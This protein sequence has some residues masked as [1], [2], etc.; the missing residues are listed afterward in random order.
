MSIVSIDQQVQ[1]P[2]Y[3]VI[4][5]QQDPETVITTRLIISDTRVNRVNLITIEKGPQG[6]T[7]PQGL[8]G[9]PGKDG[10]TFDILS[11]ASGGTNN[12]SFQSGYI[13]YYDGNKIASS[14]V[15]INNIGGSQSSNI[16]GVVASS[17]LQG[18]YSNNN[19]VVDLSLSLG[20]G[21][22]FNESNAVA[23]DNTIARVSQLQLGNLEGILPISKGGTN[24]TFFSQNRLVYFDGSKIRSLPIE[25]GRFL[26]S[27]NT[28]VQ[29]IAGSGL[30]GGGT[31]N[32]P[33]GSIVLNISESSDIIIE[34]NL[35]RLSNTGVAGNY[36]KVWTDDK[37]RVVSGSALTNAD[38]I[39]ILGYTPYH[40]GNDGAGSNLDADL[41]DGQQGAFY[42][43]ASN[44]TGVLST[45]RLPDAPVSPGLYTKVAINT[46]G[47]VEGVYYADQ[48]DII[49]SLGYIPLSTSGGSILGSLDV[50]Q[51]LNVDGSLSVGDNLP[52]LALNNTN[53]LPSAPRGFT[54]RYGGLYNNKTGI[55]AYYP[56]DNELKLVTNIFASGTD[57]SGGDANTEQD[58]I[59]G[60][61]ANSIFIVDNLEGSQATVLL[62]HIADTLYVDTGTDQFVNGLKTFLNGIAVDEQIIILDKSVSTKPPLDVKSNNLLVTNLN[63]DLLDGQHGTFYRNASNVTGSFDY[64][65]VKFDHI[66]GTNN[67]VP[68]FSDTQNP[69]AGRITNSNL[70]QDTSGNMRVE[71]NYNLVVGG[72]NNSLVDAS[73]SLI[74]GVNNS[75]KSENSTA[76]GYGNI[77]SGDNSLAVNYRSQTSADAS[78]SIAA[79]S[80]GHAWLPNQFAL[81]AFRVFENNVSIQH[82]QQSTATMHLV[83]TEAH[84]SWKTLQPIVPIP[85]NKSIGY[86]VELLISKAFDTGVAHFR[87]ESGIVKNASFRDTNNPINVINITSHPQQA[88]KI[89]G[90][91]NSQIKTHA[92][93]YEFGGL[94]RQQQNISVT[95]IPLRLQAVSTQNLD[96]YY[97]YRPEDVSK[98]GT[99]HRLND[100]NLILDI[101]K[102]LF[103]GVFEQNASTPGIR[104]QSKNHQMMPGAKAQIV[105]TPDPVS[106]IPLANGAHT[107]VG[108]SS[109]DIFYTRSTV[110]LSGYLSYRAHNTQNDIA[111]L[112]IDQPSLFNIDNRFYLM[113]SGNLTGSVVYNTTNADILSFLRPGMNIKVVTS[114]SQI[115]DRIVNAVNVTA[116]SVI[117]NDPIV[118]GISST[119][120]GPVSLYNVE[121]TY[122]LLKQSNRF[123][124]DNYTGEVGQFFANPLV[125]TSGV[126]FQSFYFNQIPGSA[127]APTGY[128]LPF[129]QNSGIYERLDLAHRPSIAI[130]MLVSKQSVYRSGLL[131]TITPLI[132]NTGSVTLYH[133]LDYS[134]SY[135]F[136]PT[137]FRQYQGVYQRFNNGTNSR[138]AIFNQQLQP[139]SI[140]FAPV[141]Y[142]LV[143]GYG[144]NDNDKFYISGVFDQYRLYSKQSLDYE[145][146][147]TYSIRIKA[148]DNSQTHTLEQQK[149]IYLNNKTNPYLNIYDL[150][151]QS[152]VILEP[153]SY[154]LPTNL[155]GFEADGGPVTL[156]AK[157]KNWNS[158]PDWLTFNT[159]TSTFSGI[160]SGCD[161]GSQTIRVSATNASGQT[162]HIDLRLVITDPSVS[163]LSYFNNTLLQSN[164]PQIRNINLSSTFFNENSPPSSV[165]ASLSCDGSYYPFVSFETAY[166]NFSGL[167]YNNSHLIEVTPVLN[168]GYPTVT[169]TG[170]PAL[171]ATGSIIS[172]YFSSPSHIGSLAPNTKV[173][174]VYKPFSWSGTPLLN[175]AKS[176][177]TVFDNNYD[178][179][180]Y[181]GA[182]ILADT[183]YFFPRTTLKSWNDYSFD[184]NTAVLQ[185]NDYILW[186]ENEE[187]IL[188]QQ[189][190]S[191]D[192]SLTVNTIWASGYSECP[193]G[194]LIKGKLF[195]YN[196]HQYPPVR[197]T[198]NPIFSGFQFKSVN[199][200]A[201]ETL[202]ISS[203]SSGT[204]NIIFP[205]PINNAV[206]A[207]YNLGLNSWGE[208]LDENNDKLITDSSE[209]LISDSFFDHG[210]RIEISNN[211]ELLESNNVF[212]HN[213]RLELQNNWDYLLTEDNKSLV[214]DYAIIAKSGD[215]VL[216]YPGD[217]NRNINLYYPD[218]SPV[219]SVIDYSK[220]IYYTLGSLIDFSFA[221][222]KYVLRTNIP[223][224]GQ[225]AA[226]M[227]VYSGGLP[228]TSNYQ[229]SGLQNYSY[230]VTDEC[231]QSSL[232]QGIKGFS[233][234]ETGYPSNIQYSTGIVNFYTEPGTGIINLFFDQQH[235]LDTRD[236]N[237]VYLHNFIKTSSA[238]GSTPKVG[239]YSNND[240]SN[241]GPSS[242]RVYNKLL[243]PNSGI[244]TNGT[245]LAN[246]DRNHGYQTKSP[247]FINHVP[248]RFDS[249]S[250]SLN[251]QTAYN[252]GLQ[253]KNSLFDILNIVGNK[254]IV[255]DS[256]NYL[257]KEAGRPDHFGHAIESD[258][259]T[260]GLPFIGSAFNNH[261]NFYDLRYDLQTLERILKACSFEYDYNGSSS[262]LTI[263]VPSG[264]VRPFDDL[265][266]RFATGVGYDTNDVYKLV[267]TQTIRPR[268]ELY[269][270]LEPLKDEL[271]LESSRSYAQTN[272]TQKLV[273]N[274]IPL[275]NISKSVN[276]ACDLDLKLEHR[277]QPGYKINYNNST[278]DSYTILSIVSGFSFSGFIPRYNNVISTNIDS[279]IL[280]EHIEHASIFHSG[281]TSL[282][283]GGRLLRQATSSDIGYT[284]YYF[285]GSSGINPVKTS[286]SG[287][288]SSSFP[289]TEIINS[290][291]S[292]RGYDFLYLGQNANQSIFHGSGIFSGINHL[293][294]YKYDLATQRS[295]LQLASRGMSSGVEP[296]FSLSNHSGLFNFSINSNRFDL[297]RVV[298]E[299]HPSN[300]LHLNTNM[301]NETNIKPWI[302]DSDT[303]LNNSE[304]EPFFPYINMA[305]PETIYV[306]NLAYD[307]NTLSPEYLP[308]IDPLYSIFNP[309]N[310][311][312]LPFIRTS[313]KY[314][315]QAIAK[316][317][318]LFF[319]GNTIVL[320]NLNSFK[321]YSSQLEEF[322]L[323]SFNDIN[324]NDTYNV[325]K[326]FTKIDSST[327]LYNITGIITDGYQS[328]PPRSGAYRFAEIYED[329]YRFD[330]T[331]GTA[332][333]QY[334]PYT[335]SV[336]FV[337]SV[338]GSMSVIDS[339]NIYYHTYGGTTANWPMD[340]TG[341]VVPSPQTGVYRVV[342]SPSS[343]SSGTLCVL[344]SG[345][346]EHIFTN[347]PNINNRSAFGQYPN[348]VSTPS[349]TGHI[350][351]YGVN[352]KFY[353]DFTDGFAE[354]NGVYYV[355][356]MLNPNLISVSIPYRSDFVDR[357]GI[358]YLIESDENIKSNLNPNINN[359]FVISN[360]TIS[361]N[362]LLNNNIL[363]YFD[364]NTK[365][366][367]HVANLKYNIPYTGYDISF[368][369]TNTKLLSLNPNPIKISG[370]QYKFD[371]QDDSS[372]VLMTNNLLRI[373][374]NASNL[375]LKITT[376]DGDQK[377]LN[378][379]AP[380]VPKIDISGFYNYIVNLNEPNKY[381]YH[382]SGWNI[383][384]D[385][386]LLNYDYSS[387]N[388]KIIAKDLTGSDTVAVSVQE[389]IIPQVSAFD[390]SYTIKDSVWSLGFDVIGFDNLYTLWNNG[391]IGLLLENLPTETYRLT[392]V[393]SS[394]VFF[395]GLASSG[396]GTYFPSL[397]IRDFTTDPY[398]ILSSGT[399]LISVLNNYGEKPTPSIVLNNLSST[400]YF[401]IDTATDT[402]SF[403]IP[404]VLGPVPS[405]V[406]SSLNV[407]FS[408]N[409]SYRMNLVS[410]SYDYDLK[411]FHIIARPTRTGDFNYIDFTA[412]YTNQ[413][414]SISMKQ[415]VY[416]TFG[417]YTYNT[418]NRS[419]GM[420]TVFYKPITLTKTV[421]DSSLVFG[422]DSPWFVQFDVKEGITSHNSATQPL[423]KI[424]NTPNLGSYETHPIEYNLDWT[425]NND[426]K[427][428]SLIASAKPDFFGKYAYNTGQYSLSISVYDR[429]S[430]FA[431]ENINIR[432]IQTQKLKNIKNQIFATK[433]NEFF[434]TVDLTDLNDLSSTPTNILG[435]LREPSIQFNTSLSRA[436]HD[437]DLNLWQYGF[438]GEKFTDKYDARI[439]VDNDNI[440]VQCKGLGNDTIVAAARLN[441][442]EI[443]NTQM[444]TIPLT[445]TGI[446]NYDPV[447][448]S[449]V[450]QG[451]TGW[452]LSFKTIGGLTDYRYPPTIILQNMPT[453]C[454]GF[455][456]L[457][458]PQQQCVIKQP[459]WN[460]SDMGGSWS[461]VFSGLPSCVLLGRKDFS[462]TAIDT[463]PTLPNPYLPDT[464]SL[465]YFFVYN[466]L[467]I[468]YNNPKIIE[469]PD[470][471]QQ[472]Q[473]KPLCDVKYQQKLLFG[474]AN[475]PL[476]GSPTGIK[477]ISTSGSLPSGLS[478][479]IFFPGD[480]GNPNPLPPYSNLGSGFLLIEGFPTTFANG[481]K[482]PEQFR[483]TVT[484][485]RDK[486][487][488]NLIE[489]TDASAPNDPN[490]S[491]PVYFDSHKPIL[492]PST[493][494]ATIPIP[495]SGAMVYR[496]AP[497]SYDLVC[498]SILP[499]NKCTIEYVNYSGNATTNTNIRLTPLT[500]SSKIVAGSSIYIQFNNNP[501]YALNGTYEVFSPAGSS[502]LFI[503]PGVSVI[504]VQGS[505]KVVIGL[506]VPLSNTKLRNFNSFF[507]GLLDDSTKY[508][509]LGGGS[510]FADPDTQP[511]QEPRLGLGGLLVPT[512]TGALTGMNTF[513]LSDFKLSQISL[514]D[515]DNQPNNNFSTISWSN[516]WETGYLRI[517]GII[518]PPINAEI[519]DP[520]PAQNFA[521]FSFNGQVY[522]LA[523][524][525]TFGSSEAQ[526]L[527]IANQRPNR[528]MNYYIKNM[529]TN[530]IIKQ[531]SIASFSSFDTP[532]L[533]TSSGTVYGVYLNHPG[534][535]F[536]T[537]N[538]QALPSASSSYFWVHKG[539]N[540]AAEPTET[541]FPALYPWLSSD[542]ISVVNDMEDADPNGLVMIPVSGAALGGYVSSFGSVWS[543]KT[544]LPK[545]S[546]I[547]Q[548]P[549]EKASFSGDFSYINQFATLTI[550]MNSVQ[551]GYNLSV[552][553]YKYNNQ[554]ILSTSATKVNLSINSSHLIDPVT[555]RIPSDLGQFPA[556]GRF[557]LS[558]SNIVSGYLPETNTLILK[559]NGLSF[560]SGDMVDLDQNNYT[561]TSLYFLD[562]DGSLSI[563]SFDNLTVG[564]TNSSSNTGWI[565]SI[566]WN[567]PVAIMK[568]FDDNIKIM[569]YNIS[570]SIEGRYDFVITG[571][572]N[573]LQYDYQYKICTLENN[574]MPPFQ[575]SQLTPKRY[576][577]NYPLYVNKP[578]KI[579]SNSIIKTGMG[580]AWNITFRV[581][582]GSRPVANYTPDVQISIDGVNFDY[583][584]FRRVSVAAT[585]KDFYDPINDQLRIELV[586]TPGRD[587]S[588]H[589]TIYIRVADATGFDTVQASIE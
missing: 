306:P 528:P 487:Q 442:V 57:I 457:I 272:Y 359:Q 4:S 566:N 141:K 448:G 473:M 118:S 100:G 321:S 82:A 445:I 288:G 74:V 327:N 537:Y 77:V 245:F 216:L 20:E 415:P 312:V 124:V 130:D 81:G 378:Q 283:N 416:D 198:I 149:Y 191:T 229:I 401:N 51:N 194:D 161:L 355:N 428:W 7:G 206:M 42:R 579:L 232:L 553:L 163:S 429:L 555:L 2:Q 484:D 530:D 393:G 335:G 490:I 116:S 308:V 193:H 39:N 387:F 479:T 56:A 235:N 468:V 334:L 108:V 316:N 466:E 44:L 269:S 538:Y 417:N 413:T 310:Y 187:A 392:Y 533:E 439:I 405:Q 486:Q 94:A 76:I 353:M 352:K 112:V 49:S 575:S 584:G 85:K 21:L 215:A 577:I 344:I 103:S 431:T 505:G 165:V 91:N 38:I 574:N 313:H 224:S 358:V 133:K 462:I 33:N 406:I 454:D 196:S 181:N 172:S 173:T 588:V 255:N 212:K 248:I 386:P 282:L 24:N 370:I 492:T 233:I 280:P 209:Q 17:G 388:A 106:G 382:G 569:P 12:T 371:N 277:L 97:Y 9:P 202:K 79:G 266:V 491:L 60:G 305:E 122:Y 246:I 483:L 275:S 481:G 127:V 347:I 526:K 27:G 451:G 254:V 318:P 262:V 185:E 498:N 500:I 465:D 148:E 156:S 114:N 210:S 309:N 46:K 514:I 239:N 436:H 26:L 507:N 360:G 221:T 6:D 517:S 140:P 561:S 158:L 539:A 61:D 469:D 494:L 259:T 565:D 342:D 408:T 522:A 199:Q 495:S 115:H 134:G 463:N 458:S 289:Y 437:T 261:A 546:G 251:N 162:T 55:L 516:C 84:D 83:G 414:I 395:T 45:D 52:I 271:L 200:P 356:D 403:D 226:G 166:N 249:F 101:D 564:I 294:I 399:G 351:P 96:R 571:R 512:V 303:T 153:F 29:V 375:V 71:T 123:F 524:K 291:T 548:R 326:Y 175:S 534:D 287:Q 444:T 438:V 147:D 376:L 400:Y 72:I 238:S 394:S 40:P 113:A 402:L 102:P 476:C 426:N 554:G 32:V 536:P 204:N 107:V 264:S 320:N 66:S 10:T 214:H 86:D 90:F 446:Q 508:C 319:N 322:K 218:L 297:F 157:L 183:T 273:F 37:G 349:A 389:K 15:P 578:I 252:I 345:F 227:V 279:L 432:Y 504:P 583:C 424:H 472:I 460:A 368:N 440:Q 169:L 19:T 307:P 174:N 92:H 125:K 143:D 372:F 285:V 293:Q 455:N 348:I 223:Y 362:S 339:N 523:T 332:N 260:N 290:I 572:A 418:Y 532:V 567:H 197:N 510:I 474:P 145:Q 265:I 502:D 58:D 380:S 328:M 369:G 151:A 373:P 397:K 176:I 531:G 167:F 184:I 509:V 155:F 138:I 59:N 14:N 69:V 503:N 152:A 256:K 119:Y 242:F 338:S 365:R 304:T 543:S 447:N 587:W 433:D 159:A 201:P 241:V 67:F 354:I 568:N 398:S 188:H 48:Q 247:A 195:L 8:P 363:N 87:F 467:P 544:Y 30:S 337:K 570:G 556:N 346:N 456:P 180:L 485:A 11:I 521:P 311:Y 547:I 182:K 70:Y 480:G 75:V 211:Y 244:F 117:I 391:S 461:Y 23:V 168:T 41:L 496:P 178:Y 541:S 478:Y 419:V 220:N 381:N 302:L 435:S 18:Y 477:T 329:Q 222:N 434:T 506:P 170:T 257:L 535:L 111:T 441:M 513:P 367:K 105:F 341:K 230:V 317:L 411:R 53:I 482:Y 131:A 281:S 99:Y 470:Y 144:D 383:G 64:N 25:T 404:A 89:I 299:A 453:F 35:I 65:K 16:T 452:V 28:S 208:L 407:N 557:N 412:R 164:D 228:G 135:Q 589:S 31:L 160:P 430:S 296:V 104:I 62:R 150:P 146:Q 88:Q 284:D 529:F 560:V 3:L 423:I 231:D 374:S 396:T 234:S 63:S 315:D 80:Y 450:S 443:E 22:T 518:L 525:L 527:L 331:F 298:V 357:K 475:V 186:T 385:V 132:S 154:S 50:D 295:L 301:Q 95:D 586:G 286:I 120:Q 137:Q 274:N 243:L 563:T 128:T 250:R 377:L 488:S 1:S 73:N 237:L 240:I 580:S 268:F 121:Y 68:K 300:R 219:D 582:G 540:L 110:S 573:N 267:D 581:T 336:S 330:K 471:P 422:L 136:L 189:F 350:R 501:N 361:D 292:Q 551:V 421:S 364:N 139:I 427:Y 78:N 263:N 585:L 390:L 515:L 34:D 449:Q 43:D 236:E 36:T 343:C 253:P 5:Q 205:E 270:D 545:I 217:K 258:Y 410:S 384:V 493:G 340:T 98:T 278:R 207:V 464:D 171:L 559:H 497:A 333:N 511:P 192:N 549:I 409:S 142:S 109:K 420:N 459:Q 325:G 54:F 499:H 379:Y 126:N 179:S 550:P 276:G 129:L 324:V 558:F 47:L 562:H 519:P 366:W 314:C 13:I 520:P 323:L 489:F 93:T 576:F 213:G 425:Y 190:K 552:D 203:M 177:F 542:S 225:S